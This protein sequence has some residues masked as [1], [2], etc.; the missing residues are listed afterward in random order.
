M[1]KQKI[2]NF[3]NKII[4]SSLSLWVLL[5]F[6]KIFNLKLEIKVNFFFILSILL[7]LILFFRQ[8]L[9]F[10]ILNLN[11][12]NSSLN[13]SRGVI[14]TQLFKT[15]YLILVFISQLLKF[16]K[17]FPRFLKFVFTNYLFWLVL[18]IL[19]ILIDIFV[20]KFSSDLLIMLLTGLWILSI[21]HFKFEGR[22][23]I[24]LALGFLILCPFLLIF[25][26]EL[27]AEKAAVWAYMFLVVG[28]VQ[29]FIEHV[30]EERKSAKKEK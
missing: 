9:V 14:K 20:F 18:G 21:C 13:L 30:K 15:S 6:L 28:V 8:I 24:G 22:V 16:F 7:F 4:Y 25:K 29:M 3:L 5:V 19:G 26:K 17:G 1:K 12:I 2:F 27:I 23:S 10:L 11:K